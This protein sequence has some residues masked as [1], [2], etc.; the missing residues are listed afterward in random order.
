MKVI[1]CQIASHPLCNRYA[2][3]LDALCVKVQGLAEVRDCWV[4]EF[5]GF[6]VFVG[7]RSG[8]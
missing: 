7:L 2:I 8:S 5:I 3:Q 1:L 6:I 4:P